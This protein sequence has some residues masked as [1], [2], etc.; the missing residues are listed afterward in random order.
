M[1]CCTNCFT[2]KEIIGFILSNS[3]EIGNCDFC[4]SKD[5]QIIDARELE[6]SFQPI[7]ALFKPVADLGVI[8]TEEKLLYE[9]IQERWKIFKLPTPQLIKKLLS[10]IFSSSFSENDVL[11]NSPVEIELLFN[12]QLV[13]DFHEKKWENFAE[14][15]KYKNRFFL[16]ETIDLRLLSDLLKNFSK[17]YDKGKIFYRARI[18]DK[19]G[20][21]SHEMGKPSIDKT[22]AGRAN[23]NGI[24]YLYLSTKIETT[25]Y[26]SRSSYLDFITIGE[27]KLLQ[28]LNVVSLREISA[29]SPFAFGENL[30]NFIIHHKYLSRL[31]QELSKPV[32]RFDKE[33]D[34][35][36][37]QYLCE[38]VKSLGY[39]A[40]EYGSSLKLGGI[41]LA[42]FN[43]SM[44]ECKVAEIY[45]ISSVELNYSKVPQ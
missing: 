11:F 32:R 7:I 18:S 37:S 40:I 44:L 30:E 42:V 19:T 26:E 3:T 45:E 15:I 23:P 12:Q 29:I 9:N 31:E 17:V 14:E 34:Y 33:L 6:E 24:P 21:K 36:P 1:N 16:T 35:L 41:N 43:D 2:D 28:P 10:E 4:D 20:F 25:I 13:F 8:I 38:Y 5:V 22:N 27:F 39:D